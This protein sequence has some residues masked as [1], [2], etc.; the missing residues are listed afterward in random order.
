MSEDENGD[1]AANDRSGGRP[2]LKRVADAPEQ[3][4][5]T[6]VALPSPAVAELSASVGYD[7]VAIDA[8]HSA[9]S[10]ETMEGMLRAIDAAPGDSEAIV[11][12]PDG[13]PTTLKR[14][15][16]RGPDGILVPMVETAA[17][18]E[19][20]VDASRYPPAGSRG[21]GVGRSAG[22]GYSLAEHVETA[23]ESVSRH[24]QLESERAVDNAAE[25]AAVEGIDGVF[26][27]PVDLSMSMGRFGEWEDETFLAAVERVTA[28]ARDAGVAVGTLATDADS[29]VAR[30]DWDVDYVVADVDVLHLVEGLTGA[31]DH[32]RDLADGSG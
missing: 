30:F 16:D 19:A 28:A 17:E 26:V 15:L 27:G 14:T 18:A 11:R 22:Y 1:G 8:E 7:F 25:I 12:L 6:W 23:D 31:L 4:V 3:L 10:Y 2:R 13:D 5:G 9:M 29:R 20:I 21:L 24:V 32:A